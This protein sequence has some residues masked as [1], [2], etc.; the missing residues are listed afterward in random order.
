MSLR[1]YSRL[2]FGENCLFYLTN[3]SPT[4]WIDSSVKREQRLLPP[5]DPCIPHTQ[6]QR[7]CN[8]GEF[9]P[10]VENVARPDEVV[11]IPNSRAWYPTTNGCS[12]NEADMKDE[13]AACRTFQ[14]D[15]LA[16]PLAHLYAW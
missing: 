16:P 11:R 1:L 10:L 2:K 14:G 9:A 7:N 5:C 12:L 6:V 4:Q 15:E 8:S 13:A 3:A